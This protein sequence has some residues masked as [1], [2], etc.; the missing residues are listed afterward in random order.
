MTGSNCSKVALFFGHSHMWAMANAISRVDECQ[1]SFAPKVVACGLKEIPGPLV[2]Q[3]SNRTTHINSAIMSSINRA[4]TNQKEPSEL[5]LVSLVQGNYYNQIG[6]FGQPTR[7]DFVLPSNPD[8][9]IADAATFLPYSA[10]KEI[11]V[12][13]MDELSAFSKR[14]G[15]FANGGVILLGSPPPPRSPEG[16]KAFL[17]EKNIDP[18]NVEI[19]D[20]F[21]RLKLWR[22]QNEITQ[23]ICDRDGHAFI[24]GDMPSVTDDDGFLLDEFVKD[25]AHA[26]YLYSLKILENVNQVISGNNAGNT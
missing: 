2:Y 4:I 18:G 15:Q 6:L 19:N 26:N 12:E 9:G 25:F 21:T 3:D 14:I 5:W 20:S 11:L 23:E 8:M 24:A 1:M 22:L 10:I 13:K 7:F 17:V 16:I